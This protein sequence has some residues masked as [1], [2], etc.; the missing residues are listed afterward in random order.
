MTT[1]TA[2]TPGLPPLFIRTNRHTSTDGHAWGWLDTAPPGSAQKLLDDHG[3]RIE[4]NGSKGLQSA[5]FIV[6]AA[7]SFDELVAAL[8]TLVNPDDF[9]KHP[10]DFAPEWHAARAALAKARQP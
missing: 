10:N 5:A 8:E 2:R 3:L 7:N 1:N 4:W 9:D 6:R